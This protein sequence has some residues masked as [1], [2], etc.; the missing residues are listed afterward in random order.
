MGAKV[1]TLQEENKF[2]VLARFVSLMSK[3]QEKLQLAD[4]PKLSASKFRNVDAIYEKK[5]W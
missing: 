1:I 4:K 2:R 3:C 5:P